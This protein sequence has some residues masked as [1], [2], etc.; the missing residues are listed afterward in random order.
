MDH[1]TRRGFCRL[2]IIF[3]GLVGSMLLGPGP[4]LPWGP[5][6]HAFV[7]KE[8]LDVGTRPVA[9]Y[10]LRMGALVPDFFWY[11][12]EVGIID[13]HTALTLHGVTTE[14]EVVRETT[15]FYDLALGELGPGN[16]YLWPFVEGIRTHVYA[17]IKA[18]NRE[19]GYL[20][21]PGMWVDV[22]Q[23]KTGIETRYALHRALETAVDSLLVHEAGLQISDL[24]FSLSQ[25][26]FLEQV[27]ITSFHDL[28]LEINF[29]VR[30]ELSRY[31]ALMRML[32]RLCW[33][34]APYL[35]E[36]KVDERFLVRAAA[37]RFS[38]EGRALSE[39]GLDVYLETLIVLLKWPREIYDTLNTE[40]MNWILDAFP[41]TIAF[42]KTR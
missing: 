2:S 30:L 27:M 24:A 31:L 19:G 17:D 23:H 20:E 28:G 42:C 8:A 18:H 22:L 38:N 39:A 26:L 25:A 32:E 6:T 11:L 34:Y 5:S 35:I 10:H 13:H 21:G 9:G 15:Y 12:S 29:D 36:G 40:G 7:A 1:Q 41:E 16:L 37:E 3:M 4:G 33:M 14:A